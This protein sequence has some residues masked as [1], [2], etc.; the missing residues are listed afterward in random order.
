MLYSGANVTQDLAML[1]DTPFA[2][3]EGIFIIGEC[4]AVPLAGCITG[5]LMGQAAFNLTGANTAETILSA[6]SLALTI[7]ADLLDDRELGEA[8][9][10]SFV[11]FLAGGMSFDPI[12][13]LAIDG[14]ASG[15]NHGTFNGIDTIMTGGSPFK[16]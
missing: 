2:I 4:I 11:T 5:A 12:I 10:T 14:Y 15:Y 3:T 16:P 6:A 1:I 7:T 13:D 8:S 9:R